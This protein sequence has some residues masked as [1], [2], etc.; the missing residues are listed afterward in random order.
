MSNPAY[1]YA[2]AR[3][4]LYN[5]GFSI[6]LLASFEPRLH[7]MA[8]WWKQLYGESEGK[9]NKALFPASVDFTT[10]LHSMGQY[11]QEGRR[12]VAET[13]LIVDGSEPSLTVPDADD[14]DG[15]GYLMSKEV[16]YVNAK[17]YEA[18]AKAHRD[19]GVPNMTIHLERLDA[20]SLGA[21]IYFFEIA[22]AVSGLMLGVN[23]FN[24]PGVEA[25]KKEMFKLL[26]K[27]GF[28][29]AE[30]EESKPEYIHF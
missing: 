8:E 11:I 20:N 26:G 10:D 5:Q 19:G 16:S 9:E 27:P 1:F 21:L 22:C 12:M 15:L 28:E 4:V 25:Y 14:S 6:E 13:F 2:A 23:P 24:Q 29:S 3:N 30:S 18:T 17:A 7:F